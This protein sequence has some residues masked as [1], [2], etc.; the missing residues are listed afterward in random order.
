MACQRDGAAQLLDRPPCRRNTSP[1][2]SMR[3]RHLYDRFGRTGGCAHQYRASDL[4]HSQA[5]VDRRAATRRRQSAPIRLRH[6]LEPG[7]SAPPSRRPECQWLPFPPAWSRRGQAGWLAARSWLHR[8]TISKGLRIGG[9]AARRPRC[10]YPQRAQS[11]DRSST[12]SP[13][14][15][16]RRR[17]IRTAGFDRAVRSASFSRSQTAS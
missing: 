6:R 11:A 4:K 3:Q 16:L 7:R 15:A 13:P 12:S 2:R 5:A 9:E 8:D 10:P 17:G 1:R 14:R